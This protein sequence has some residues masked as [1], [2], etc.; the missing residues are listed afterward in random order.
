VRD[1]ETRLLGA[2][3]SSRNWT[4]GIVVALLL[5]IYVMNVTILIFLYNAKP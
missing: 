4:I 2:I 1:L 3:A 5:P